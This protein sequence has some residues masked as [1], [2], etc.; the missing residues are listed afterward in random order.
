MTY[1]V[2]TGLGDREP[3]LYGETLLADAVAPALGVLLLEPT[4][5]WLV[6]L[7][8]RSRKRGIRLASLDAARAL[9]ERCFVK[10]VDEKIRCWRT[11]VSI[12]MQQMTANVQLIKALG[13]G[14]DRSRIAPPN[15]VARNA[16]AAG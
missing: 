2:P 15:E 3:V 6:R 16:P 9:T 14:W 11:A 13:G 1:A 10:P 8:E 7:P 4:D 12:Q 5:D